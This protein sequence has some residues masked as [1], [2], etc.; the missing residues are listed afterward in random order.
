ME[1]LTLTIAATIAGLGVLVGLAAATAF[2]RSE[3]HFRATPTADTAPT[4]VAGIN[5]EVLSV[6]ET[7]EAMSIIVG[8]R[9]HIL[10]ADARAYTF[11]LAT[12]DDLTD[13]RLLKIVEQVRRTGIAQEHEVTFTPI[14]SP[15]V[16]M[17]FLVTVAALHGGK[18]LIMAKDLTKERRIEAMR[19]DF[20]ANV[21]HEL[22]TPVGA[23]Q[24]LAET[25]YA[26]ADDPQAVQTFA[27][28][29]IT[30]ANRLTSLVSD[31]VML[32]KLQEVDVLT[33]AEPTHLDQVVADALET[34]RTAAKQRDIELQVDVSDHPLVWAVP[35][36]L[37][38]AVRNLIDNAIRY[39]PEH[40]TVTIRTG[41]RSEVGVVSVEDEG[42]GISQADC[43]RIFE[44]FYRVDKGRSR[45]T[46]GTGLGLSIVKHTMRDHG[47]RVRVK[48]AP[49]EGSTFTLEL[50]LAHVRSRAETTASATQIDNGPEDTRHLESAQVPATA[51]S[52]RVREAL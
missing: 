18:I 29:M 6:L 11:G 34:H 42:V 38:T 39:S 44:R 19:T 32:S 24:L 12:G 33:H 17:F 7:I 4:E 48:S 35:E 40:T 30:E 37:T 49:G 16:R 31:I 46:G 15:Q 5:P 50:P 41:T 36:L 47:G 8:P 45:S 28:K 10:R 9:G 22:K 27:P 3:R 21:S 26:H 20:T 51:G 23:L 43:E 1:G 25:I 2:Y 52:P 14:V 13:Q